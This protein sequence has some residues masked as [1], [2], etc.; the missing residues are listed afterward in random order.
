[1]DSCVKNSEISIRVIQPEDGYTLTNGETY[2]KKIYLGINDNPENW[3]EIPD[4][5]IPEE[6]GV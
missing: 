2:S 4:E 5:Q 3:Y 1:M 6:K